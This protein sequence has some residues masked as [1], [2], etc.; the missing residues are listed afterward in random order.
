MA[1][2]TKVD[3]IKLNDAHLN[4]FHS[5]YFSRGFCGINECSL[6]SNDDSKKL[7]VGGGCD[8]QCI[9]LPIGYT[10]A[11]KDGYKLVGNKTCEGK[12]SRIFYP[13]SQNI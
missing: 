1:R 10:C 13:I 12:N 7:N 8:Q 5:F 3:R 4:I 9:D 6:G 2:R 11:C